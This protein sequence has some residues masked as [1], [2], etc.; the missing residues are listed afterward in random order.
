MKN[1]IVFIEE[2][3]IKGNNI[4]VSAINTE[5]NEDCDFGIPID[6]FEFWLHTNS[7]LTRWER[8]IYNEPDNE[9]PIEITLDEYWSVENESQKTDLAEYIKKHF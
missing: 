4:I 2:Y 7:L 1:P 5:T 9:T 3:E 8:N 6:N